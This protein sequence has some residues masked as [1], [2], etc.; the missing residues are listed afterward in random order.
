[1]W[2]EDKGDFRYE[3]AHPAGHFAMGTGFASTA[4]AK[5]AASSVRFAEPEPA[6]DD[7]DLEHVGGQSDADQP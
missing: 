3:V 7:L 2:R 5:A 6:P 4:A 1:M